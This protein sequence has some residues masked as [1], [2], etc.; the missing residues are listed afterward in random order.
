L[1][2]TET[3]PAAAASPF[4][5]TRTLWNVVGEEYSEE[6]AKVKGLAVSTAGAVF[7]EML[8]ASV[9]AQLAENIKE[10]VDG[11]TVKL[12]GHPLEGTLPSASYRSV[13]RAGPA[14]GASSTDLARMADDGCPHS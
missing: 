7:R 8:T 10:L 5:A 9:P 14:K 6:L 12:G 13:K 1:A 2:A 3:A 4:A 11:V